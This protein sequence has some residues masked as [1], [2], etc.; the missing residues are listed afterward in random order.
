MG[1]GSNAPEAPDPYETASA[2]AQFNRPD[3]YSAGGSSILNGYTDPITGQFVQGV[4][5]QGAQAAQKYVESPFEQALRQMFEPASI[6]LGRTVL[7][8]SMGTLSQGLQ[9]QDRGDVAQSIF[10]RA[11]SMMSPGIDK[12]N[13]RLLTNLQARGIPVGAE[14]FNDAYGEQLKQTQDTI[15]RLAMDADIAS[16]QEQSRQ[17]GLDAAL[18][19]NAMSEIAAAMGGG[20]N[21]PNAMPSGSMASVNYSGLVGQQYQNEMAQY[22]AQQAQRMNTASTLGGL[23]ASMLLKCTMEAKEI[24]GPLRDAWAAEALSRMPLAVWRYR[25]SNRPAGDHGEQHI[26]PMAEHFRDITGLGDGRTINVI[27]YL[28]LLAGALQ[29]ALRRIEVMERE[30][31]GE[32]VH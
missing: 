32:G 14:G 5:P 25:D 1:K 16:G 12:A 29:S 17:F 30:M 20:Y 7:D 3:I 21:P 27:D 31:R 19:Q 26:G 15:S 13:E 18:R 22:Q 8:Q 10:D 6:D 23:G 24:D 4:A 2:E 11:F 28:G 9:V